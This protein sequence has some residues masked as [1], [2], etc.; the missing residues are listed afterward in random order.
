MSGYTQAENNNTMSLKIENPERRRIFGY[1][2][3]DPPTQ[4][5]AVQ[6]KVVLLADPLQRK[7]NPRLTSA[8]S[9]LWTKADQLQHHRQTGS[10]VRLDLGTR[11]QFAN[12]LSLNAFSP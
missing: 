8:L 10:I 9:F 6:S 12:D 3:H 2:P 4:N 5:P 7:N 1:K 11:S